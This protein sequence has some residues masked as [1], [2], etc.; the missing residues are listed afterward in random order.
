MQKKAFADEPARIVAKVYEK[1]RG[2][3]GLEGSDRSGHINGELL[4]IIILKR[5]H[6]QLV[7]VNNEA[8]K[9]AGQLTMPVMLSGRRYETMSLALLLTGDN[10]G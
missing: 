8:A 5:P 9:T 3:C 1:P 7:A 10:S 6:K 2:S 4:K